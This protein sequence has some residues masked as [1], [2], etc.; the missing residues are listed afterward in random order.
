MSSRIGSQERFAPKNAKGKCT[1]RSPQPAAR[2]PQPATHNLPPPFVFA[3]YLCP[4]RFAIYR[5]SR[6]SNALRRAVH[7]A[8]RQP[9]TPPAQ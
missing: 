2:S 6:A 9:P 8:D 3:A 4:R 1:M 7:A 5:S